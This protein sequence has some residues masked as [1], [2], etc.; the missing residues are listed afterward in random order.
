M[1]ITT[2]EI[3]RERVELLCE[4][5]ESDEYAQARSALKTEHGNCCLG[6]A[7]DV[8]GI[9]H[10]GEPKRRGPPD[11]SHLLEYPY[12]IDE[13]DPLTHGWS[14]MPDE[15]AEWYG[16]S[17]QNPEIMID[18]NSPTVMTNANDTW[19]YSF[20][21]IARGLLPSGQ[22]ISMQI[23]NDIYGYKLPEMAALIRSTYL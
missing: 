9:G 19:R 18:D 22:E 20:K 16:F 17:C 3:N 15:V 2:R 11:R 7:C 10:W 4:K 13:R 6:V 23:A 1:T 8:S 21:M 5:L 14:Y 12:V